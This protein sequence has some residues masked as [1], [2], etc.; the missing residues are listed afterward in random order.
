MRH[1]LRND[2]TGWVMKAWWWWNDRLGVWML[3]WLKAANPLLPRSGGHS[4]GL[5]SVCTAKAPH[6]HDFEPNSYFKEEHLN[7]D[8]DPQNLFQLSTPFYLVVCVFERAYQISFALPFCCGQ[9][10]TWLG[11]MQTQLKQ[12]SFWK[13][14]TSLYD[15]ALISVVS[16]HLT[17]W[18]IYFIL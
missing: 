5:R 6:T 18:R 17:H 12:P 11:T 16:P 14:N 13:F 10:S 8:Q 3:S 2:G 9:Y 15:L 4:G 7:S 1:T